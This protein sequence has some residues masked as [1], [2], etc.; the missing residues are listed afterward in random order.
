MQLVQR[1]VLVSM[2]LVAGA[3]SR[4]P[5]MSPRAEPQA[6]ESLYW[7]AVSQLDAANRQGSLD[8]ALALLDSYLAT[9]LPQEHRAEALVLR[10]LAR[11]AQ[12][13][14]RVQAALARGTYAETK[15]STD[16]RPQTETKGVVRDEE[17]VKEVQRLKEEL[18]KANEELERIRKRLAPQKPAG[19]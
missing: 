13:L 17:L 9:A 11:D 1:A 19:R 10:Q 7:S 8:S 15:P 14:A 4:V 3:C 5:W 2:L 6:S 18:A 16:T 12:Q